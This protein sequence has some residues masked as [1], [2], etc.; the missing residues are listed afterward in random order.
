M[1]PSVTEVSYQEKHNRSRMYENESSQP[2]VR[3][4]ADN[5][6]SVAKT[7]Y[8]SLFI[9]SLHC[10]CPCWRTEI[11]GASNQ[12][13]S[14]SKYWVKHTSKGG[15][16]EGEYTCRKVQERQQWLA[17][18]EPEITVGS[19]GLSKHQHLYLGD[20][21]LCL[22]DRTRCMFC[23]SLHHKEVSTSLNIF[24]PFSFFLKLQKT[25][26]IWRLG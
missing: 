11:E 4:T 1:Y 10:N 17:Q 20:S 13:G 24:R 15:C 18:E 22:F 16:A 21:N 2:N 23:A 9:F 19:V 5:V 14:A 3:V 12:T 7:R 25:T 8:Y 6:S 26:L